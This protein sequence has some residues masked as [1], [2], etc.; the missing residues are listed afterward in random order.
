LNDKSDNSLQKM[1]SK[2]F[3]NSKKLK[4]YCLLKRDLP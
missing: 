2:Q 3:S 1:T 4:I